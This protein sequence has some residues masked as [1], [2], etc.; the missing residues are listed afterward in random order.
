MAEDGNVHKH[1]SLTWTLLGLLE[2]SA[3]SNTLNQQELVSCQ[4]S[5]I[6]EV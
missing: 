1:L 5:R 4:G 3:R 6:T 2:G